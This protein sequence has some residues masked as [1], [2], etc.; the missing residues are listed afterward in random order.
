M[1]GFKLCNGNFIFAF[2][3][4]F[5]GTKWHKMVLT[6][7]SGKFIQDGYVNTPKKD[8]KDPKQWTNVYK[9][10]YDISNFHGIGKGMF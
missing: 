5:H 10:F 1:K 2:N 6:T 4:D 8:W 7:N 9:K 3:Y